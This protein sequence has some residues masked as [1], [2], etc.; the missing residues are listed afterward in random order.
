MT[1]EETPMMTED[2]PIAVL[3]DGSSVMAVTTSA[4]LVDDWLALQV[5]WIDR[6]NLKE[7]RSVPSIPSGEL[8]ASYVELAEAHT[9]DPEAARAVVRCQ[10]E[11]LVGS[12]PCL[13][14]CFCSAVVPEPWEID[15]AH[16]LFRAVSEM[17]ERDGLERVKMWR[18]LALGVVNPVMVDGYGPDFVL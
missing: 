7:D 5:A 9:Q 4:S 2:A 8:A 12:R 10:A 18:Y 11:I 15:V 14:G 17:G 13:C 16:G 3:P 6:H 1:N